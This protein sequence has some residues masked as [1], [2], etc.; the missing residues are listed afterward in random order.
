MRKILILNLILIILILSFGASAFGAD[1]NIDSVMEFAEK[2]TDSD[3]FD[4][5]LLYARSLFIGLASLSLAFGLIRMILNGESNLGTAFS[6]V[7]RWILYTGIFVWIM[8]N[9]VPQTIINS[10]ISI[11]GKINGTADIAPDD[12][13][14][15]GIRIYG[16]IVEQSWNAG[17]GDFV[18]II[19]LG[20]IILVAIALIAGL[21]ALALI[22]MHLVICG[23][24]VLLGFG[25]FIYTRDIALSYI[26]YAISVGVKLMMVMILYGFAS[27]TIINWEAEFQKAETMSDLITSSSQILGGV[28]CILLAVYYIPKAAQSIVNRATMTIGVPNNQVVYANLLGSNVPVETRRGDLDNRSMLGSIMDAVRNSWGGGAVPEASG[29]PDLTGGLSTD[30][31]PDIQ[32]DRDYIRGEDGMLS[33]ASYRPMAERGGAKQVQNPANAE[34]MTNYTQPDNDY[35]NREN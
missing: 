33:G 27:S 35:V 22:N 12:I 8:N 18:G 28:I 6:L 30:S 26:K 19:F 13:M 4:T 9:D 10:F 25:G 3:A 1:Y 2:F 16:N 24:A 11:G 23:G 7:A 32:V 17:W 14:S 34:S 31:G 5:V 21:F 29:R 20:L 15:A